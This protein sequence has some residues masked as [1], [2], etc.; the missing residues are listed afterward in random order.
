M[1]NEDENEL[2]QTK[3]KKKTIGSSNNI[4]NKISS[5]TEM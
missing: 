3:I 2:K 1:K 5:D 4:N